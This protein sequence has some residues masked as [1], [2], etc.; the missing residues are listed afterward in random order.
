MIDK[1]TA[2]SYAMISFAIVGLSLVIV[3]PFGLNLIY[4]Q[5]SQIEKGLNYDKEILEVYS[6]GTALVKFTTAPERMLVNNEYVNYVTSE[7]SNKI[8]FESKNTKLIFDKNTNTLESWNGDDLEIKLSHSIKEAIDGTDIWS[9]FVINDVF[10]TAFSTDEKGMQIISSQGD[11]KTIYDIG[12][13]GFEYTYEYT[14]NNNLKNNHKYGFTSVCDGPQCDN[15]TI[16]N[17]PVNIGEVK[18][19]A[20]IINKNIKVGNKDFDLKNDQHGYTWALKYPQDNKFIVDF[21][22]SKGKLNYLD[23]L[24]R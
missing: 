11:F 17:M 22:H 4:A 12:L 18:G 9:E 8:Y 16:D 20:D 15:I 6:D 3:N 13:N 7:D 21:T 19:K 10:Q 5:E 14:N 1:Q 23:T 2:F 24:D